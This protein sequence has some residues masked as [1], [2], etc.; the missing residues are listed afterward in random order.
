[1]LLR[2]KN[3]TAPAIKVRTYFFDNAENKF[4]TNKSPFITIKKSETL[5]LLKKFECKNAFMYKVIF[6][7]RIYF[8]ESYHFE[9]IQ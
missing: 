5:L 8:M 7:G 2:I 9:E 1:M 4:I 3:K 6:S